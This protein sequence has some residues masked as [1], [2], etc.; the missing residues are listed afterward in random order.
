MVIDLDHYFHLKPAQCD[1]DTMNFV[2]NVQRTETDVSMSEGWNDQD[3]A[4]S[5]QEPQPWAP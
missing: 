5:P 3:D 4:L 2:A 1:W